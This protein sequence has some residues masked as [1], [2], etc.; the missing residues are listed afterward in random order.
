MK[1]LEDVAPLNMVAAEEIAIDFL[2][3]D[4]VKLH[5]VVKTE[6][7]RSIRICNLFLSS[8][9]LLSNSLVRLGVAHIFF[10]FSWWLVIGGDGFLFRFYNLFLE[11]C[12]QPAVTGPCRM[13]SKQFHYDAKEGQ[14]KPFLFG[15]CLGNSNRFKTEEACQNACQKR[16]LEVK[17]W[18]CDLQTLCINFANTD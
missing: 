8:D 16:S 14:C 11:P 1:H 18:S 6:K 15:G 12:L 7:Q 4:P 13:H 2:Q 5:V 9:H 17:G 10:L 3:S